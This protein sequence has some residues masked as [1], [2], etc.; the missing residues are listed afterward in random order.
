MRVLTW[1]LKLWPAVQGLPIEGDKAAIDGEATATPADINAVDPVDRKWDKAKLVDFERVDKLV[2]VLAGLK[3]KLPDVIFLEEVVSKKFVNYVIAR[4]NSEL[5]S[6]VYK[7]AT[8]YNEESVPQGISIVSKHEIIATTRIDVDKFLKDHPTQMGGVGDL[9]NTLH[10]NTFFNATSKPEF[11]QSVGGDSAWGKIINYVS[12]FPQTRPILAVKVLIDSKPVWCIGVHLKSHLPSWELLGLGRQTS[13]DVALQNL[14]YAINKQIREI[15]AYAICGFIEYQM[16]SQPTA[17]LSFIVAGDFNTSKVKH[18][19]KPNVLGEKTLDI[20]TSF[21]MTRAVIGNSYVS[22]N[23]FENPAN[24]VDI[25]HVF[26]KAMPGGL[27]EG[28]TEKSS[29]IIDVLSDDNII[30]YDTVDTKSNNTYIPGG[31]YVVPKAISKKQEDNLFLAKTTTSFLSAETGY[32]KEGAVLTVGQRS[33]IL[34]PQTKDARKALVSNPGTATEILVKLPGTCKIKE[35]SKDGKEGTVTSFF[36]NKQ[37]L[38]KILATSW[39]SGGTT[40]TG[41]ARFDISAWEEVYPVWNS[42]NK[43]YY[44]NK[45]VVFEG[46]RYVCTVPHDTVNEIITDAEYRK[47]YWTKLGSISTN[48]I[49]DHNG[50]LVE[51]G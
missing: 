42:I 28:K 50:L 1:N 27:L 8:H 26:W 34:L 31:Y 44:K 51:I 9:K 36:G 2:E 30:S 43:S 16:V 6:V 12:S 18:I 20:L 5:G 21:G 4:V 35:N 49:S 23:D 14:G 22:F 11:T 33:F 48:T 10:L 13:P 15:F 3:D 29:E 41:G 37:P 32:L 38:F 19:D 45:I 39:E 7:Y 40:K 25:D 17:A 47:K 24:G 46:S